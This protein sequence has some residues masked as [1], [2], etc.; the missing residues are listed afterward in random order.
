VAA[1]PLVFL[2]CGQEYTRSSRVVWPNG[3]LDFLCVFRG[4]DRSLDD[5]GAGN[6]AS[7]FV[8]VAFCGVFSF[9]EMVIA[10]SILCEILFYYGL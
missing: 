9:G 4:T 8:A 6:R 10:D 7:L 5:I 3:L 2:V 1:L